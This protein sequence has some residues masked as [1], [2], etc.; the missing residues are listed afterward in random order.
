VDL[1][2]RRYLD[3]A[4]G[5]LGLGDWKQANEELENISA[6]N[7]AHP[8]ALRLRYVVYCKALKWDGALDI[9]RALAKLVPSKSFGWIE[10]AH[11]LHKLKRTVEARDTL[12]PQVDRF[13]E[14]WLI[15]YN[16]AC[17]ECQLGNLKAAWD[18][19]EKTFDMKDSKE[20]KLM[21]L[22]DEN[23]E[24]LWIDISEI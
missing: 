7:R 11:L 4:A 3:A 9:A 14:E 17:Y 12:L 2:D 21:A 20:V 8:D 24:P 16:L 6:P 15:R 1:N 19:L 22:D 5:W 13:P 23:L 10:T 18:W